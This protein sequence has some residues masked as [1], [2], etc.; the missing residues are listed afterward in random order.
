MNDL[1]FKHLEQFSET[2][3]KLLDDEKT[4]REGNYIAITDE[5]TD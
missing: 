2:I 3:I 4:K 5:K 1:K